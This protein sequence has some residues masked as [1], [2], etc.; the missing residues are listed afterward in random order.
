MLFA[1]VLIRIGFRRNV[2]ARGA[3]ALRERIW[4]GRHD[5]VFLLAVGL[6]FFSDW[7]ALLRTVSLRSIGC[8]AFSTSANASSARRRIL[9][10]QWPV[11]EIVP[12]GNKRVS[13]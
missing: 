13:P 12:P 2:L 7:A 4:V 10:A 3:L 5:F 6:D 11:V 8:R 9:F 1:A